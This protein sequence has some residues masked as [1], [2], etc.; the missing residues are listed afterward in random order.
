MEKEQ[1]GWKLIEEFQDV[2]EQYAIDDYLGSGAYGI[3]CAVKEFKSQGSFAIKKC[4]NIFHSK[5][6]AKRTLREIRLLRYINHPKI[7]ELKK[8][9]ITSAANSFS[10]L[11][12]LFELMDTDL[13]QV[14]KSNQIL[15]VEHIQHFVYQ[16]LQAI[17]F[18]HDA[19]II[20]RDIK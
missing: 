3:V 5:T 1:Q 11:Y 4:K 6:L 16:L 20:H 7:V 10:E 17:K 18:L 14:I 19:H 13:S 8:V 9:F 15:R 12:M 2:C